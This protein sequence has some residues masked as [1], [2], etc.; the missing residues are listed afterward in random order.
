MTIY[1]LPDK[2]HFAFSVFLFILYS[3]DLCFQSVNIFVS[4]KYFI[5][6]ILGRFAQPRL[7]MV[8]VNKDYCVT[9]VMLQTAVLFLPKYIFF[10]TIF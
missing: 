5:V 3:F 8:S 4:E 1:M 2:T 6:Q 7:A 9:F 10:Q